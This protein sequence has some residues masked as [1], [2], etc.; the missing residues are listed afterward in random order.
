[1]RLA[2]PLAAHVAAGRPVVSTSDSIDDVRALLA[3]DAEARARAVAVVAGAAFSPGY[4]CVL[5]RHAATQLH[6]GH[7]GARGAQW[8]RRPGL[9]PPAPRRAHRP[10]AR[11]A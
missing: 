10:G 9:R 4:S 2:C 3:L 5:A 6:H 7:R 11:L 1:M 8:H